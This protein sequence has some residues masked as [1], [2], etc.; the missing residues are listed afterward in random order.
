MAKYDI[1]EKD[2]STDGARI[3]IV[4]AR[5]NHEVVDSLLEGALATLKDKGISEHAITVVRVPGAFELPLAAQRLA[6][7]PGTE[8]VIAL[9]AVINGETRHG[10]YV[11]GECA[12][13]L[14][15]VSLDTNL[16]VI[17]GVLTTDTPEQ[18]HARAGGDHGNKG[19]EAALAALEMIT[20]LR[21]LN[22][23]G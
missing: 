14:N 7:R 19:H 9:G 11:S 18:A 16:P 2:F 15:R 8:A 23:D 10:D 21:Q 3:G 13:G 17:F 6:R 5:F 12:S 22:A 20:V 1:E 4:A